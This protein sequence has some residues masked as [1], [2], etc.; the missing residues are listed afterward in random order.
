MPQIRNANLGDGDRRKVL[1]AILDI[2]VCCREL[3]TA[4]QNDRTSEDIES[5]ADLKLV[6][7]VKLGGAGAS[8]EAR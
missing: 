1:D 7:K 2:E 4:A 3:I 8:L 5:G 6:L